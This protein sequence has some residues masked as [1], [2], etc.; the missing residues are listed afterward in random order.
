M[1][2]Y[3]ASVLYRFADQ[4]YRQAAQAIVTAVVLGV[5][6]GGGIG[7]GGGYAVNRPAAQ[8]FMIVLG[9]LGAVIGYSLGAQRAFALRLQAQTALCQAKIEENTR[10][11][12]SAA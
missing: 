3:D 12:G 10:R 1:V 2:Q 9:L 8:T 7:Y 4:L 6:I 5:I 11:H